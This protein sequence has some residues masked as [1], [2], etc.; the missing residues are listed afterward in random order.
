MR[1]KRK[2]TLERPLIISA[3]LLPAVK[4]GDDTLSIEFNE[5]S[6]S[7]AFFVDTKDGK[8]FSDD[9]LRGRFSDV[10]EVFSC[11]FDFMLACAESVRFE[12]YSGRKGENSEL[13]S[14]EIVDWIVD[15]QSAIEYLQFELSGENAW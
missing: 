9:G 13:F 11:L 12:K 15:N 5:A 10:R 6:K 4:V 3:R 14:P 1:G 2:M 8:T 7:W